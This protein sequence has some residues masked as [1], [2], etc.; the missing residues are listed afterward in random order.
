M[1]RL[2][3]W[4]R[5]E[6]GRRIELT[7][8]LRLIVLDRFAKAAVLV[9]GG[10]ALLVL[11]RTGEMSELLRR[12]A[13]EYNLDPGT[14]LWH[15]LVHY[16]LGVVLRLPGNRIVD[17]AVAGIAYGLLETFEGTGLLLRRRWAEYLVL[18]ATLLFLPVEIDELFKRLTAFRFLA[19]L[20][21]IAIV[22]YLIWRKRLFLER[23]P[24]L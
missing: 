6:F 24:P 9:L 20:I 3:S 18:L 7:A 11:G 13:S 4:A 21:N 19:L 16:V 10:V 2:G 5:W 8:G 1:S 17:L 23:P 14:G 22:A 12:V 15:Q